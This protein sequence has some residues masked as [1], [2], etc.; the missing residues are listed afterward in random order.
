M[1]RLD[2]ADVQSTETRF[3]DDHRKVDHAT[4]SFLEI[5]LIL[6]KQSLSL[7]VRPHVYLMMIVDPPHRAVRAR[8]HRVASEHHLGQ[9]RFHRIK[10]KSIRLQIVHRDSSSLP[11]DDFRQLIRD[12]A[13]QALPVALRIQH[14]GDGQQ[15]AIVERRVMHGAFLFPVT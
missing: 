8:D 14:I 10:A 3:L 6:D 5:T 7:K 11:P 13:K 15:G 4:K 1:S 2:A 9:I 12:S